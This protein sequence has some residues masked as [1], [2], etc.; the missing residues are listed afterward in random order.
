[1]IRNFHSQKF[2]IYSTIFA[3]LKSAIMKAVIEKVFSPVEYSF[4]TEYIEEI[5]FTSKWHY[6]EKAE[7]ILIYDTAGTGYVGESIIPFS[8][9]TLSIIGTG[10]L[11]L[12]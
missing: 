2:T 7:I 8:G 3:I 9:D 4:S 6:H 10:F 11:T 1:M 12:G 5:N